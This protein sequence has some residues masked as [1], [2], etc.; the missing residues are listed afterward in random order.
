[1]S[2]RIKLIDN[3]ALYKI[4]QCTKEIVKLIV[5]TGADLNL[6]KLDDLHDDVQVSDTKIFMLQGINDQTVKTMGFT[7]LTFING[8]QSSESEFIWTDACEDAFQT[9]RT[10]LTKEPI[11]Q[12]P[13][14]SRPFNITTDASNCAIG[15]ILSQ[16][17]IGSDLPICY[18]SRTLNKAKINYNTTEKDCWQ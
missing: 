15:G 7:M 13:D 6:I 4:P 10:I 11:L 8:N 14:F 2:F 12:F 18:A 16:G 9:F 17:N 3:H 5:D 1:M